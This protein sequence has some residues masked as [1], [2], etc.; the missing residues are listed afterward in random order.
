[1]QCGYN[2]TRFEQEGAKMTSYTL[3]LDEADK[4]AA[5]EVAEYYGFDLASVTRAFYKQMIR[6]RS[7]PLDLGRDEPNPE[8]LRAIEE[9]EAFFAKGESGAYGSARELLDAAL[10]S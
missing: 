2:V 8:S 10:S 7:I 1:M 6:T 3:R 5:S 9:A 4:A